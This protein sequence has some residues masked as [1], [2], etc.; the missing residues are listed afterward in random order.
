MFYLPY[1]Y[2]LGLETSSSEILWNNLLPVSIWNL[3]GGALFIGLLYAL[4]SKE[5]KSV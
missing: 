2:L 3:I 1:A 4:L 5:K